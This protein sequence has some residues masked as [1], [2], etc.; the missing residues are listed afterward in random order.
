MNAPLPPDRRVFEEHCARGDFRLGEAEGRWKH[1]STPW[2]SAV[3]EVAA[4]SRGNAPDRFA[5]CF[6][7]SGYPAGATARP[8]DTAKDAPLAFA[9]WPAGKAILPSIFR[10]EWKGGTC[11]YW[12]VD[13]MSIEGHDQWR[14]QHPS[15]LWQSARGIICYL[16][17]LHDLLHSS[18][19]TGVRCA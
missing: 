9:A 2:P 18:D 11:L 5:F 7:L 4:A 15:R 13:R 3:I 10:P 12:P 17:Q 16:E 8:W 1:V 14:H 6:V 19:Y